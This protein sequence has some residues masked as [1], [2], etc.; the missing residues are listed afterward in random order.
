MNTAW[1][2]VWHT[3][4]KAPGLLPRGLH[5]VGREA[6]W[7]KRQSDGWGYGHGS[8]GVV[9]HRPCVLGAFPD[10]RT[11]AHDATR[12]WLATGHR[13]GVI[14]TVIR[15]GKA[16]DQALFAEFQRQRGMTLVRPCQFIVR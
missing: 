11:R 10:L 8:F 7:G 15:D 16:E 13:R 14:T 6:T 4:H 12:R 1:G 2:P 9:S 3:T 5:G